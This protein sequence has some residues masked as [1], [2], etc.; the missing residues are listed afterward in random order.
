MKIIK[1]IYAFILSLQIFALIVFMLYFFSENMYVLIPIKLD[2][3]EDIK[4]EFN[5]EITVTSIILFILAIAI[6]SIVSGITVTAIG[7]LND[8]ATITVREII[9]FMAIY[10]FLIIPVNFIFS[11]SIYL[12][13]FQV[14]ID[15]FILLV[16]LLNYLNK[17]EGA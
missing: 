6:I 15:L 2:L 14:Y 7:G 12:V 17:D 13:D 5:L 8:T 10:S 4:F 3:T 11:Q 16:Y 1:S 9:S